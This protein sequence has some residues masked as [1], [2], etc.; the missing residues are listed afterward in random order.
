MA[1]TSFSEPIVARS[2]LLLIFKTGGPNYE[3]RPAAAYAALARELKI[4]AQ[5]KTELIE[6]GGRV[7]S[8]WHNRVRWARNALH[9][10]GFLEDSPRGVWRLSRAGVTE[11]K[12]LIE[13]AVEFDRTMESLR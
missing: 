1:S 8:K 9:K 13:I 3:V 6:S 11:A 2:L 10:S 7:E 12:R 5:E 4:S